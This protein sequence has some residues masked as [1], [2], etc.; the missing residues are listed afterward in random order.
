MADATNKH[1][2]AP[3]QERVEE[4]GPFSGM[5]DP[6]AELASEGDHEE[7]S[8][9]TN[10]DDIKPEGEVSP[11]VQALLDKMEAALAEHAETVQYLKGQNAILA[12]NRPTEKKEEK[13]VEEPLLKLPDKASLQKALSDPDT[14]VDALTNMFSEF[15]DNI[16]K[17]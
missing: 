10:P 2:P 14:A 11:A 9:E 1:D 15:G 7:P 4:N 12:Q 5:D 17:R 8:G 13:V 16:I 6:I 3:A